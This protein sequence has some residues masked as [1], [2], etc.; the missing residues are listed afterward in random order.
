ML[1]KICEE[2]NRWYAMALSICGDEQLSRDIVQDMYLRIEKYVKDESKVIEPDGSV[3]AFYIY[4]TIKNIYFKLF[5]DNK[6]IKFVQ[7]RESDFLDKETASFN[8]HMYSESVEEFNNRELMEAAFQRTVDRIMVEARKW[9]WYDE[10]LFK[11]YFL[12]DMSLRDVAQETK[13]SLTSIYNSIRNYKEFMIDK[14][15]ED[16]ED[17]YNEDYDKI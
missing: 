12:T 11:L 10:K 1:K 17:Y 15:A 13:I 16:V 6:K 8:E 4:V 14:F 7:L 5:N 3:N 2:H 9:H